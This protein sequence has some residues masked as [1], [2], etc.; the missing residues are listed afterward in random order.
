VKSKKGE[1][2]VDYLWVSAAIFL[3]CPKFV[4]I[5]AKIP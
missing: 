5:Q 1:I 2:A 3:K 4:T